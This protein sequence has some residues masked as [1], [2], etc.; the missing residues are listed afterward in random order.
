MAARR[1]HEVERWKESATRAGGAGGDN[2]NFTPTVGDWRE[3]AAAA[4]KRRERTDAEASVSELGGII[5]GY[6][7]E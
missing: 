5:R 6:Y 7:A 4:R 1:A 3:R 2:P